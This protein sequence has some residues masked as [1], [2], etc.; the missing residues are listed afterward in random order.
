MKYS[1]KDYKDHLER[2]HKLTAFSAYLREIV[3]G[4]NFPELFM[5]K[6][7]RYG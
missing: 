5:L 1:E 3:Y 7:F 6:I 4:I 2:E